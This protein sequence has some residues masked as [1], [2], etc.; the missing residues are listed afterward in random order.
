M[1]LF[2]P[3]NARLGVHEYRHSLGSHSARVD[4]QYMAGE[5]FRIS[6]LGLVLASQDDP[7]RSSIGSGS[8][9]D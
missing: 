4:T 1:V 2:K 8:V 5:F 9:V 3:E 7:R 6:L